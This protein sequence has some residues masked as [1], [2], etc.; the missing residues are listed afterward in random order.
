MVCVG[1]Q[2]HDILTICLTGPHLAVCII[3]PVVL[4]K[5]SVL[6][7][8]IH[9]YT[10]SFFLLLLMGTRWSAVLSPLNS[11]QK[12]HGHQA[13]VSLLSYV[14]TVARSRSSSDAGRRHLLPMLVGVDSTQHNTQLK[15]ATVKQPNA[16]THSQ[17]FRPPSSE[18]HVSA[19]TYGHRNIVS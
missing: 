10:F 9:L 15:D 7:V 2:L 1:K 16:Q 13:I 5:C 18:V 12:C 8:R 14:S 11:Q 3:S 4:Y 19:C 17:V 6:L